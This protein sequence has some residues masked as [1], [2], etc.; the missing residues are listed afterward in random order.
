MTL[1]SI[2]FSHG[3]QP[4]QCRTAHLTCVT[5]PYAGDFLFDLLDYLFL[6][7]K[8]PKGCERHKA[9]PTPMTL[10]KDLGNEL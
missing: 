9:P 5:T 2:Y 1:Q 3:S 4:L 10:L 6:K 8:I 7:Q